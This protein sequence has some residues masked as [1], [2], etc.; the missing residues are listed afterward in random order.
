VPEKQ[1]QTRL[2]P[3]T[4]AEAARELVRTLREDARVLEGGA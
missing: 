2:I 4:P 1:K 3:G